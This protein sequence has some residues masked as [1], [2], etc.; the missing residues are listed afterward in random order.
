M[1]FQKNHEYCW[2][3]DGDESLD[4]YPLCFKLQSDLKAEL[5]AIPNWQKKLRN[6]L[7]NLISEWKE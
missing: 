3:P 5:K 7:P 6:A 2:K 1:P 4:R